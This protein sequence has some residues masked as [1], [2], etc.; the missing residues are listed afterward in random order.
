MHG[1]YFD[2]Y[3]EYLATQHNFPVRK[4]GPY[5]NSEIKFALTQFV[6]YLH[7]HNCQEIRKKYK[8]TYFDRLSFLAIN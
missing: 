4:Y 3:S 5:R 8:N 1:C 6:I 7:K 2:T